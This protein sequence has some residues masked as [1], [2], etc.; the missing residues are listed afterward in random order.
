MRSCSP[1]T[2]NSSP[3]TRSSETSREEQQSINEE[4]ATVNN[5]LQAKIDQL[6]TVQ[7][8]LKNLLDNVNVGTIFLDDQLVIRRFTR[9]AQRLYR[10]V[11]TDLGR[12]LR[13]HIRTSTATHCRRAHAPCSTLAAPAS[14]SCAPATAPGTWRAR[15]PTARSTT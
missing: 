7:N 11:A 2:R 15:R 12:R 4:M 14:A 8:D 9:E 5:E 13:H 10:L 6:A 1:P 3:P